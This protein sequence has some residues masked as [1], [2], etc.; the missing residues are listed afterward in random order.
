MSEDIRAYFLEIANRIRD[1][2]ETEKELHG[3]S[4]TFAQSTEIADSDLIEI[5]VKF[6]KENGGKAIMGD[7]VFF[8]N[9]YVPT[10]SGR[11]FQALLRNKDSELLNTLFDKGLIRKDR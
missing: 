6:M 2:M 7:I 10:R 11:M 8:L 9:E 5:F 3:L 4:A 1:V